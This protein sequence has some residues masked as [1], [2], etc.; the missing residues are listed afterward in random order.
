[1]TMSALV[2]KHASF[3]AVK[4]RAHRNAP[5]Y[6]NDCR[7]VKAKT[8]KLEIQFRDKQSALDREV[9]RAHSRYQRFLFNEKYV[10]YWSDAIQSNKG[11]SK[12]LWS[13]IS[14]LLKASPNTS[15]STNTADDFAIFFKNKVDVIRAATASAPPPI[16]EARSC[17]TLSTMKAFTTAEI[18]KLVSS[19]PSKHCS[20][21]PA[22]TWL[23]KQA[24]PLLAD[25]IT[26]MCNASLT[27]GVFPD[28]LK[29]AIVRPRLKKPTLDP[30]DLRSYRPISNLSFISKIVE[31]A[32]AARFSDH[33]EA[34]HLLP[35]R[36]S[37]YR[38]NHSTE[39]AIVAVH[40][41]L[42]RN[43]DSGKASVLVLLDLSTAFDTVDH[44]TLPQV[45]DRRF[46]VTG[47]ALNWF[48][49]YL[50]G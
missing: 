34:E 42:V 1:M 31:R 23:V 43:I 8:R 24:L 36:Q 25:T 39:T 30:V 28:A 17:S 16:I 44:N 7:K 2:D 9:W 32:V 37:A 45:L 10:H 12:A 5:W 41:E 40:D 3:A 13:K 21:D 14:A 6:D 27:E 15:T 33:V 35:S 50:S 38:T 20:L 49:S 4:I 48:V 22:P 11:D 46:G 29:Q 47:T 26:L 18:V 19:S